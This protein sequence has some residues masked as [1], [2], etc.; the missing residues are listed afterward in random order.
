M[1]AAGETPGDRLQGIK[2]SVFKVRVPNRDARRGKRGGYRLLYYLPLSN[3]VVLLTIYS[4]TDISDMAI[5]E[6]MKYL[7]TWEDK[8]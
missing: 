5:A 6:I 8:N 7:T 1:L 2:Q 4:K 3:R